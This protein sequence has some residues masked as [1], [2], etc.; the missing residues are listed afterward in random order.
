MILGIDIGG[1]NTKVA[2]SDGKIVESHYIPLWKN[3]KLPQ[4]LKDIAVRLKPEKVGVVITGELADCFPDK[5]AGIS[6]IVDAINS[7]FRDA[8]FLDNNGVFTKDKKR[9]LAAANWAASALLIAKEHRDCIFVD[10]G[11]T[12]TDIIPIVEGIPCAAKTDFERLKN[13]ELVYTG[14]LR[15]NIAAIFDRLKINGA[16][17][18]ISSELFSITAD[19]Y[20][21][22]GMIS[23]K[24][25]TCD[26]PDLRGKTLLDA[27]RRLARVMCADLS[28]IKENEL[29]S[30][31][32]QVME[33]QVKDIGE[34]VH[35]AVERHNL[36]KIVA[37]GLG[38]FLVK[39]AADEHGFD[40]ILLS[41]KYGKEISKV[42]PAYAVAVLLS[43]LR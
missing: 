22:L 31:A 14:V 20:L 3:T 13:N 16:E 24:E 2:S 27:R 19:A 30:L 29:V 18:R 8:Y 26:T 32:R 38:E 21:L 11:S 9:S 40:I 28:E 6:Y 15:T 10:T 34:A 33:K 7:A 36:N 39:K 41:E 37:C 35:D 23:E 12:T 17:M 43:K 5:E 42:F 4:V 1:A 25:Y